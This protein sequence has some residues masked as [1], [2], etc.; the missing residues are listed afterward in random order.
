[1]DLTNKSNKELTTLVNTLVEEQ[2]RVYKIDRVRWT[3]LVDLESNVKREIRNRA[4][5]I[6]V[7]TLVKEV[8]NA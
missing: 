1:M 3:A 7:N 6:D 5:A 2:Q 4:Q 8:L